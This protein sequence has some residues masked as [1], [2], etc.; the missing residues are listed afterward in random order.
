[1]TLL[2]PSFLWLLVPLTLFFF[3]SSPKIVVRTHLVILMLLLFSL[4]RP[5]KEASLQES[6]IQARDLIIA[7][8][9]SYSMRASDIPPTRYTFAK[10]TIKQLL[11]NNPTD[12]VMLM[13]FTSNPLLLSPPTTDHT[14]IDVALDA[15]NP[16]F[17]LTKGTSLKK[18]FKKLAHMHQEKKILLLITDGGEEHDAAHLANILQQSDISLIT[19]ALGTSKG[20]TVATKTGKVLKDKQ[21]NLVISRLNPAL[22]ELTSLMQ[23]SYLKAKATPTQT[24]DAITEVLQTQA[25]TQQSQKMQHRY[26]EL[27]QIPLF[28]A[29]VLFL[30]VHTRGVKY[31]LIAF[32]LLGIQVHAGMFD[33]YRL[34]QAYDAYKHQ[35]YSLSYQA[36]KHIKTPSLQSQIALA[37]IY[38][39]QGAYK[40]ALKI[41]DTLRSRS[42]LIKQHIYYNSANAYAQ[43]G[44][45]SKAKRYYTKALQLGKDKDAEHNLKLVT[46]LADKKSQGLGK[47]HPKSQNADASK[48]LAKE[49]NK[50]EKKKEEEQSSGSGSG[51][52]GSN[53][54]KVKKNQLLVD[55]HTPPHPLS[56]K[57][58]ELINK[59]YIRETHPW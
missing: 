37:D 38:Y 9:V 4:A 23:G 50:D 43:L 46:F 25:Q 44:S 2:Y 30:L 53:K 12:N 32:T 8:D 48:S 47:A 41:Y 49:E 19:L 11:K 52:E 34:H 27:Y 1:M 15:L 29:M 20:T 45:Y 17:I 21:G 5:V 58:Y 56:S 35:D 42:A 55:D 51:G 13:A 28:I 14:L 6:N 31:L 16:E 26:K 24:A 59:G 40:K 18:L 39:K 36:L 54:E 57:V 10:E 33:T 7:L 3:K 22:E